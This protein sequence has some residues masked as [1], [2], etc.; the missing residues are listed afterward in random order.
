VVAE[1]T[2]NADTGHHNPKMAENASRLELENPHSNSSQVVGVSH[3]YICP[4][5]EQVWL[6]GIR[7]SHR[8]RRIGIASELIDRMIRYGM[9]MGKSVTEAAA[10]TAETNTASRRM[11]EKNYFKK[12]AQWTYY[13][14]GV[15][16]GPQTNMDGSTIRNYFF[17]INQNNVPNNNTNKYSKK[18]DV[19]FASL[20]EVEEIITFLSKSKTFESSGRRYFRSW[21]WYKLD[22][23]CTR[24][25][26]LVAGRMIIVAR[27]KN[28]HKIRGLAIVNNRFRENYS[29]GQLQREAQE[30][31]KQFTHGR[32]GSSYEDDDDASFQLVYL[33]APTTEI[34]YS[35]LVFTV[36][37]VISSNKFARI[38]IFTPNQFQHENSDSYAIE[39]VL[40][41]FGVVKSE[42]FLLYVRSL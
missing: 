17:E 18:I 12:R 23:Q 24:I 8:F 29:A 26:E 22:L 40:S 38:Q 4:K 16:N 20:S 30:D 28:I 19:Y 42:R 31:Q 33:D 25:S 39:D 41:K 34:L 32:D 3:A 13:T 37:W 11:L 6:E 14:V 15:K 35:L 7:I 21:K 2:S 10:I 27:T 1:I 5:K 36:N 9:K